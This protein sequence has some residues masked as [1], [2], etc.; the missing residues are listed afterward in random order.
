MVRAF[1][2]IEI[3]LTLV[4]VAMFATVAV[5]RWSGSSDESRIN[6]AAF[7][8]DDEF[9]AVARMSRA[10]GRVHTIMFDTD[11]SEMRVFSGPDPVTESLVRTVSLKSKP[12]AATVTE[13]A[14]EPEGVSVHVDPYG[15]YSRIA[16]VKLVS[17]TSTRV[18]TLAGPS[19][20]A[21]GG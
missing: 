18:V 7:R 3:I 11:T 21:E 10:T 8:L 2:M 13:V 15:M 4:I 5:S 9:A 16:K 6:A 19:C 14:Y 20:G 1:T 12:Y 17:G